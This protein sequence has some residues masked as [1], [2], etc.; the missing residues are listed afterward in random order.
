MP[1][2]P[3]A[4]GGER[5][6]MRMLRK[7]LATAVLAAVVSAGAAPAFARSYHEWST[8]HPFSG[9]HGGYGRDSSYCDYIKYPIR[10]CHTTR[11]CRHG[12]CAT[13]RRCKVVDW[14]IRQ[15]CY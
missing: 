4:S 1:N 10:D 11:V 13:R 2:S 7:I 9:W 15:S 5:K 3:L 8:R 6:S 14:D 12:K